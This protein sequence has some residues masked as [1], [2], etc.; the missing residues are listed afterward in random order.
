MSGAAAIDSM[1]PTEANVTP[2]ITGSRIPTPGKPIHCTSV[3]MPQANRS[4]LIRKATSSGGNFSARPMIKGTATAPAYITKHMLQAER[5][6]PRRR[7]DLVD[8]MD[9]AAH[10]RTSPRCRPSGPSEPIQGS[11]QKLVPGALP[12]GTKVAQY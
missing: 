12:C 9:F 6:Q 8:R 11:C 3:A 7:Q 1:G 10:V 5:Q 4:A 2:I